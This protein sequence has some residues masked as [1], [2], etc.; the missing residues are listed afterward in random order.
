MK[1]VLGKNRGDLVIVTDIVFPDELNDNQRRIINEL[2][3]C[4]CYSFECSCTTENRNELKTNKLIHDS[5]DVV[6]ETQYHLTFFGLSMSLLE[7]T[8]NL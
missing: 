3:C 5:L 2:F 7:R 8:S 6:T 1:G 4:V